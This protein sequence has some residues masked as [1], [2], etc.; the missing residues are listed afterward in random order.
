MC[1]PGPGRGW[2]WLP[3]HAWVNMPWASQ[4]EG[5]SSWVL[6]AAG[7]QTRLRCVV[8][9]ADTT[10]RRPAVSSGVKGE[11]L[12]CGR[13]DSGIKICKVW[14]SSAEWRYLN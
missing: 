8:R 4:V 1:E 11:A 13:S 12:A 7:T 9:R 6:Q 10:E 2:R 5:A 14:K 3:S